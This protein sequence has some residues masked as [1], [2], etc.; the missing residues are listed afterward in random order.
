[1]TPRTALL[2]AAVLGALGAAAAGNPYLVKD[3]DPTLVGVPSNPSFFATVGSRSYFTATKGKQRSLWYSDGTASTTVKIA[4][5]APG[6][7]QYQP[8]GYQAVGTLGSSLVFATS[9]RS[10]YFLKITDGTAAGTRPI[11]RLDDLPT[12]AGANLDGKLYFGL[13]SSAT[14]EELWRTDGTAAGTTV[15]DMVPG[16]AGSKPSLLYALGGTLYFHAAGGPNGEGLYRT[17]GTVAGTSLISAGTVV[18][19]VGLKERLLFVRRS[20]D[21]SKREYWVTNGTAAGTTKLAETDPSTI[22]GSNGTELFFTGNRLSN[23]AELWSTDG[24]AAGTRLR[25]IIP[26]TGFAR[27]TG[28]AVAAGTLFITTENNIDLFNGTT[29]TQLKAFVGTYP[30]FELD[31]VYYFAGHNAEYGTELWRSDGT[32]A[33]TRI[34]FDL[35]PGPASGIDP[36]DNFMLR[37]DGVLLRASDGNTGDEPWFSDGIR[38][39]T[40]LLAN[41]NPEN[42]PKSG[43]PSALRAAGGR[44]FFDANDETSLPKLWTATSSGA[45]PFLDSSRYV[46]QP[47][48]ASNG[49]Y[50]FIQGD[51]PG[52]QL[53]RTD[54]TPEGTFRIQT[55]DESRYFD[56]LLPFR[57]GLLFSG[58]GFLTY[59]T[60]GTVDGTRKLASSAP[61]VLVDSKGFAWLGGGPLYKTDGTSTVPIPLPAGVRVDAL[62]EMGGTVYFL[63]RLHS[64]AFEFWRI[65]GT[66]VRLVKHV[67][68]EGSPSGLQAASRHV[69]FLTT[70]GVWSSDGTDAGTKLILPGGAQSCFFENR[71]SFL[72][73]NDVLYWVSRTSGVGGLWRSDGTAEGTYRLAQWTPDTLASCNADNLLLANG[74]LFFRGQDT[75]HGEELWTSD[76][77]TAGTHVAADVAAGGMSSSPAEL[78]LIGDVLF[79][80]AYT[81]D[82]GYELF[83]YDTAPPTRR[84]SARK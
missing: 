3:L 24:T 75:Q 47:G 38:E 25:S 41:I 82:T 71:S 67:E 60:D 14:G 48:A 9:A 70:K 11:V 21:S 53:W 35:R 1:M 18:G 56:V 77:T 12:T 34:A 62:V 66:D 7:E 59:F 46:V 81:P 17:D 10:T 55:M 29:V 28:G 72:T 80:R 40:Q 39:H 19:M 79:F 15:L 45:M 73:M 22:L 20:A 33:G 37:P 65:D 78:T 64:N 4:D 76:G 54:G 36:Y 27:V 31:G 5:F 63:D 16:T 6:I 61:V 42:V 43:M 44:L 69:F 8:E 13:T 68:G 52:L 26:L 83:A 49:L 57:N 23:G 32:A 84:R 2:L 50:Y 74:R 51:L 30:G 58:A